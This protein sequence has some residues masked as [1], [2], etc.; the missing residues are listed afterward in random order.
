[1]QSRPATEI[2]PGEL[3]QTATRI[4]FLIVGT[5]IGGWAPLIPIVKS[6]LGVDEA[7]LGALLLCVGLGSIVAMPFSGGWAARFGC[8]RVILAAS[9]IA[10]GAFPVMAGGQSVAGV[11]I[12]L[13]AFGAGIG[14]VD[15]TMNIQAVIVEKASGRS[16]MSGFHGLYSVGGFLGAGLG[17]AML[18][19]GLAPVGTGVAI[20]LLCVAL[21]LPIAKGL[22]TYG[23]HEEAP[24]LAVPTGKVLLIGT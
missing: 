13:F 22:L 23:R 19:A 10:L 2:A 8:R 14:V 12:A 3:E 1:M 11:A 7:Q 5:V 18:W 20:T 9:V 6:R 24:A 21:L 15:V 4:V 16:M 17:T